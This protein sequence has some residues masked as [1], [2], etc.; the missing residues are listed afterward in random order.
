MHGLVIGSVAEMFNNQLLIGQLYEISKFQVVPFTKRF[1][2]FQ[3]NRQ[4]VITGSTEL[5]ILGANIFQIP[6]NVFDFT[7]LHNFEPNNEEGCHL[8]GKQFFDTTC[9][10]I[11]LQFHNACF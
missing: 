3:G 7:D 6:R 1:K 8:L 2:C 10:Y 5:Q 11:V 9:L 4:I